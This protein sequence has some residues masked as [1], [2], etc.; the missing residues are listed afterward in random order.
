MLTTGFLPPTRNGAIFHVCNRSSSIM[1]KA[2]AAL[3]PKAAAAAAAAAAAPSAG[4][5]AQSEA[6]CVYLCCKCA[7]LIGD[8]G[9]L[10]HAADFGDAIT[11]RCKLNHITQISCATYDQQF[12]EYFLVLGL[13]FLQMR[14]TWC[15]LDSFSCARKIAAHIE[16]YTASSAKRN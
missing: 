16:L 7:H 4:M 3:A 10:V 14:P 8:S 5:A 9:S 15:L 1:K 13:R 6:A 2:A 11:L 12:N